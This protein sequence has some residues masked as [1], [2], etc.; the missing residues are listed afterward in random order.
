MLKYLAVQEAEAPVLSQRLCV[1]GLEALLEKPAE[2]KASSVSLHS[3]H[4]RVFWN[5]PLSR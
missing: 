4:I 1:A 2:E 3:R 5:G